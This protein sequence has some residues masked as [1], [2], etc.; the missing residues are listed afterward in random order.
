MERRVDTLGVPWHTSNMTS[1]LKNIERVPISSVQPYPGNPRRGDV[2]AIA[3]SL[4]E[5]GQFQPLIVQAST[6][7]ILAGNNTW[8]AAQR[9]DWTDIDVVT[10][11]VDAQEGRKIL[12]A[13][14]KTADLGTY[15]TDELADIIRQ[16]D[17]DISG[18]AYTPGEIDALLGTFDIPEPEFAL[19]PAVPP[20]MDEVPATGAAY[21]ETQEQ[22]AARAER[23]AAQTPRPYQGLSEVQ[24]LY[25]PEEKS[26]VSELLIKLRAIY[27]HEVRNPQLVLTALRVAVERAHL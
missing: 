7:Y 1:L 20:V 4:R 9:L 6:R 24:L 10:V 15:D 26:E 14:N 17:G 27:G 18:I 13:A 2:H 8:R 23:Q 19:P 3:E 12:L 22:E 25:T 11:D 5:N 16:L 21:A